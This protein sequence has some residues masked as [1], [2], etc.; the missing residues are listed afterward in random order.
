MSVIKYKDPVT[1]EWKT[2][3]SG[4]GGTSIDV[5]AEVGQTIVVE[6]VDADGKPT[7]WK[8]ADYQPKICGAVEALLV[9]EATVET[10]EGGTGYFTPT[11]EITEGNSYRVT[12]N[13]IPTIIKAIAMDGAVGI[14]DMANGIVI[15]HGRDLGVDDSLMAIAAPYP[16]QT[17]TLSVVEISISPIPPQYLGNALPYYI[18]VTG[19]GTTDDPYVCNDTVANVEA[20]L[21]S[22]REVKLKVTAYIS[23]TTDG[24]VLTTTGYYSLV[25]TFAL[26]GSASAMLFTAA[27]QGKAGNDYL[28]LHPQEDGSYL[29]DQKL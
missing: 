26:V 18:E 2:T 5:T 3:S 27:G 21:T 15:V 23:N 13:G 8:A 12:I 28:V 24:S 19:I 20:I 17:I 22:G 29:I 11:F 7:K 1:G 25:Q 6:E 4:G 14:A 16:S 9:H 10:D